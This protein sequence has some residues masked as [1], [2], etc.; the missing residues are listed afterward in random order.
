MSEL[1]EAWASEGKRNVFGNVVTV[2]EM[3]GEGGVAGARWQTG[4]RAIA[5]GTRRLAL[6]HSSTCVAW[7]SQTTRHT[8]V[9]GSTLAASSCSQQC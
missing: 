4:C 2:T 6:R 8:A 9:Q 5:L 7:V 3:E 1:T